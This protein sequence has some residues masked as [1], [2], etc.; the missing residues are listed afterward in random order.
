VARSV[1]VP[2][3][4]IADLARYIREERLSP[5]KPLFDPLIRSP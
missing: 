4:L 5:M 3:H 2:E 1:P